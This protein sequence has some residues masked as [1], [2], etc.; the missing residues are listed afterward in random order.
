MVHSIPFDSQTLIYCPEVQQLWVTTPIAA[1]ALVAHVNE[2]VPLEALAQ[3]MGLDLGQLSRF[4]GE[5]T[6]SVASQHKMLSVRRSRAFVEVKLN[7]AH[8]CNL[9][10]IYCYAGDGSYGEPGLMD[11]STARAAVTFFNEHFKDTDIRLCFFGG[12][13]LLNAKTIEATCAFASNLKTSNSFRFAIITNGTILNA[14]ILSILGHYNVQVTISLDGPEVIHDKLRTFHDGA[15]SFDRISSNVRRMQRRGIP[16]YY[17]AVYTSLHEKEGISRAS[18]KDYLEREMGFRSGVISD[19]TV[20]NGSDMTWL[21]PSR[22]DTGQGILSDPGLY[23][24]VR[25]FLFKW[26]PQHLCT[27]GRLYF[28]VTPTGDIYPC[29]TLVGERRFLMGNVL[30]KDYELPR[31]LRQMLDVLD[32]EKNTACKFCWARYLCKTCPAGLYVTTGIW[33][34]PE[35][36]CVA[37]KKRIESALVQLARIRRSPHK[38]QELVRQVK[39]TSVIT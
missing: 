32:K 8:A 29:Q 9:R 39:D 34:I 33:G 5:W 1:R 4:V 23:W 10:C 26:F 31:T 13:P 27:M 22:D 36:Y 25:Y 15:G 2:G 16:L 37:Q 7:V 6:S 12:E 19:V 18:L 11:A 28:A 24:P 35:D 14:K 20:R 38:Y 21:T 17:E 3:S 30:R